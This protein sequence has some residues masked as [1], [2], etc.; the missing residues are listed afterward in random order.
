ME[1][2]RFLSSRLAGGIDATTYVAQGLKP[3]K[4]YNFRVKA[5]NRF[6]TS[7][8]TLPCNML[9]REEPRGRHIYR[10]SETPSRPVLPRTKPYVSDIGKE[11]IRLGWRPA[12]LSLPH[13]GRSLSV[14]PPVSY[15]VEAQKL[16]SEEWIP[17]ASRVKKPSLYLSDLESD[18]DYNIRVRA[19]TPYGVSQPTE[20]LW[21]PRA[22]AF[23]GVPVSRPTIVEIE[24]GTARL[25]WNR[26]DIPAFDRSEEPLLY[27][28]EMQEP[29]GY[30]WRELARRVPTT[31]FT[32]RDLEPSQ[33][34]RFRVRAETTEGLLSEPSP[35][36]SI[37][38]TLAL[39]HTPVDRLEVEDYD[40]DLRSARLSWRRVEVPPYGSADEPLLY[41]IE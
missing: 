7:E 22:K 29:P 9:A 11:T 31:Y 10:E 14:P 26:V 21:I 23:T 25:Q 34:Y 4:E 17:L 3:D 2:Q 33:D 39:T 35:A 20:S 38:R 27:M 24:E 16:P 41:M 19:Q 5:E 40:E 37:F 13:A 8:P 18:R 28:V 6:G 12:E 36:T 32:V 30:R 15:R 1:S